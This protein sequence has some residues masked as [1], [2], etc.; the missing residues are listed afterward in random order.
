MARLNEMLKVAAVLL[1][2]LIQA[3]LVSATPLPSQEEDL[4]SDRE[5]KGFLGFS[6]FAPPARVEPH[7][8]IATNGLLTIGTCFNKQSC[9][10]IGGVDS[11]TCS[12]GGVCCVLPS[13]C[14]SVV[15]RN[16]TWFVN[17]DFPEKSRD[18]GDC[19]ITIKKEFPR[20]K[21]ARLDFH[22]FQLA[23]P[24]RGRC[25]DD[26]F[27]V[28]AMTNVHGRQ[29]KVEITP[30][31][32]G[33]N[34][35][36]H[37]YVDMEQGD[38]EVHVKLGSD[39]H[40]TNREWR[41]FITQLDETFAAPKDCLQYHTDSSNKVRSLNF[42]EDDDFKGDLNYDICFTKLQRTSDPA[43][44]CKRKV[45]NV[46]IDQ[47]PSFRQLRKRNKKRRVARSPESRVLPLYSSPEQSLEDK[48][49][50]EAISDVISQISRRVDSERVDDSSSKVTS[51][52]N[53]KELNDDELSQQDNIKV[54][55]A[56]K[57]N[58]NTLPMLYSAGN[59]AVISQIQQV[60]LQLQQEQ[61]GLGGGTGGNFGFGGIVKSTDEES[62]P[63][64]TRMEDDGSTTPLPSTEEITTSPQVNLTENPGILTSSDNSV[65]SDNRINS[66]TIEIESSVNSVSN[67]VNELLT[68]HITLTTETVYP[69]TDNLAVE[70]T[71]I[72]S[73]LLPEGVMTDIL[74]T[75]SPNKETV[76]ENSE[77]PKDEMSSH[78]ESEDTSVTSSIV[79]TTER[80][81]LTNGGLDYL[82]SEAIHGVQENVALSR[83]TT[84]QG[85]EE[86]GINSSPNKEALHASDDIFIGGSPSESK[87]GSPQ[88]EILVLD[89]ESVKVH[90]DLI[91]KDDENDNNQTP[92][93]VT[94]KST[95]GVTSITSEELQSTLK[96]TH[97][98]ITTASTVMVEGEQ[99]MVEVEDNNPLDS[100]ESNNKGP[101]TMLTNAISGDIVPALVDIE[102]D[103]GDQKNGDIQWLILD[104]DS[105]NQVSEPEVSLPPD[106]IVSSDLGFGFNNEGTEKSPPPS[107]NEKNVEENFGDLSID[108]DV[109]DSALNMNG[110]EDMINPES[111]SHSIT[112]ESPVSMASSSVPSSTTN[113]AM[114]STSP[115]NSIITLSTTGNIASMVSASTKTT[116]STSTTTS[117]TTTTTT[118][119]TT[120]ATTTTTSPT[121]T[122]ATTTTSPTTTAAT[123]TTSP[124]T[125]AA[126]TTT[127]PTTTAATTTTTPTITT[128]TTTATPPTT[129]TKTTTATPPTTTTKTT[130]ATPPTTTTKTTT[131]T[132]TTAKTTTATPATPKTT[133]ATPTTATTTTTTTPATTPKTT[134]TTTSTTTTTMPTTTV[135]TT[136]TTS[137][138][139]AVSTVTTTT[140]D[141]Q[142]E[143]FH[144]QTT[145]NN[146]DANVQDL[147]TSNSNAHI[148]NEMEKTKDESEE[149]SMVEGD[150]MLN[151]EVVDSSGDIEDSKTSGPIVDKISENVGIINSV[152]ETPES[153]SE[154]MAD[155]VHDDVSSLITSS[156][157]GIIQADTSETNKNTES[158]I[159]ND[160]M[161]D[162]EELE[163]AI[164]SH[165][166]EEAI[167]EIVSGTEVAEPENSS[168]PP[169]ID[170]IAQVND[171]L[172]S[173]NQDTDKEK[174][175]PED[176][177]P[178]L[179]DDHSS[180]NDNQANPTVLTEHPPINEA[181]LAIS[182]DEKPVDQ[183]DI[184]IE[185]APTSVGDN[186]IENDIVNELDASI[187]ESA[188]SL[189]VSFPTDEEQCGGSFLKV[190][191]NVICGGLLRHEAIEEKDSEDDRFSDIERISVRSMEGA[192][193]SLKFQLQYET[194][195]PEMKVETTTKAPVRKTVTL[196]Q[197]LLGWYR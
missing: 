30:K 120:T 175:K 141:Q 81:L 129:T 107:T 5:G 189:L 170:S 165:A 82:E 132:P 192:T 31:L 15:A 161:F 72:E 171:K 27:E 35:G 143:T 135:K 121:T 26:V 67:I 8:C 68:N 47:S 181:V 59:E 62:S 10:D 148:E 2:F 95:I 160:S 166:N 111:M 41:V 164:M 126:T 182:V 40:S 11:G 77:Q 7:Q 108:S 162:K 60:V 191:E 158:E 151:E 118:T 1:L 24:R 193:R 76:D 71:V 168:E 33:D 145:V 48:E 34:T 43:E 51:H 92:V 89:P 190:R 138:I 36:Q 134:T 110:N 103:D 197:Y 186:S 180:E 173:D 194:D 177:M 142:E 94:S 16:R 53:K 80:D 97:E 56:S 109:M 42:D 185:A 157:F 4:D 113:I 163:P 195:C 61:L 20:I 98:D 159:D 54:D 65:G 114:V 178:S 131:A 104:G 128:T 37:V 149:I 152:P 130:T 46:E 172:S 32:C 18:S 139:S 153:E 112:S 140:A 105:D 154:D 93:E 83:D 101:S 52:I 146:K 57:T 75:E 179:A 3:G 39:A 86:S 155:T 187:A 63:S 100:E 64:S 88:A 73:T 14:G 9:T 12:T 183:V 49:V 79:M 25:L 91:I 69:L 176:G 74:V 21:Q 23:N 28:S 87:P 17:K 184:A 137:P 127:S 150:H 38:A 70:G 188:D 167:I 117:T 96:F 169:A 84:T 123:T 144:D 85:Y 124:T 6:F 29:E 90:G 99:L 106:V 115:T 55:T 196:L 136:T 125:T 50:R 22:S 147:T 44:S 122:A 78:S 66:H 174:D 116:T 156:S 102:T 19:S 133:T 119:P 58:D 45:S 13:V